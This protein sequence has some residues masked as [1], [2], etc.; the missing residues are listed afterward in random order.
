MKKC[1]YLHKEN[2]EY[3][4]HSV[5]V[6]NLKQE[7]TLEKKQIDQLLLKIKEKDYIQNELQR[8]ICES[9]ETLSYLCL[10]LK[11]I[12]ERGIEMEREIKLNKAK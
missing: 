10:K 7:N 9:S 11:E 3:I 4:N 5:S 12:E 2:S 1:E 8:E 6:E